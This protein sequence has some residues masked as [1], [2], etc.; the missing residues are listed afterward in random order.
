MVIIPDFNVSFAKLNIV[1]GDLI[2]IKGQWVIFESERL[3]EIMAL[4]YDKDPVATFN[5]F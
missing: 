3:L 4:T 5:Y 1:A 2:T